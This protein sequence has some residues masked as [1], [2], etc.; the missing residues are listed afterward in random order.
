MHRGTI[1]HTN[2]GSV[3][4]VRDAEGERLEAFHT[5]TEAW[6]RFDTDR[7]GAAERF[8]DKGRH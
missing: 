5:R 8:A 3:D 4:L 1:Y 2:A 6:A 7:R